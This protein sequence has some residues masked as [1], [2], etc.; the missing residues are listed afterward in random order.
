[1]DLQLA[2]DPV[3]PGYSYGVLAVEALT[4]QTMELPWVPD[5]QGA[6]C[7]EPF[8]SCVPVGTFELVLHDTVEHPKTWALVNPALGI[9]HEPGDIPAGVRARFGCLLHNGN[10][11][12]QS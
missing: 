1:M 12:S 3:T 8:S 7:G 4:L 5:P 6:P 2:R 11:A 10:L 9:Y